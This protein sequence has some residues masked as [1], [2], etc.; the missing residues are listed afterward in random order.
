[1]NSMHKNNL[2]IIMVF[3]LFAS[4]VPGQDMEIY[5]SDAGNF[6]NP[7]W[8]ILKFDENGD[9]PQVFINSNL[10]WPQ[11]IVFLDDAGTVLISNF[12]GRI[13]RHD[14][15]TGTYIDDFASVPGQPTRMKIGS[16]NLLYVLQW[17]GNGKVRRYQLDGSFVDEFTNVG[18]PQS[19][20]LDWDSDGNMY[21][22]SYNGDS[23]RKFDT[24]GSD[25]G[26]FIN[27]NLVGPTDITFDSNGDLLVSDYDGAK[28]K[29]FDSNGNY[30]SDFIN[31]VGKV[32]GIDM[33]A[34]GNILVGVG[35][36]SSVRM[37]DAAGTYIETFISNGSGNLI[38]PNAIVIRNDN[39]GNTFKM[40]AGLNDAWYN[41]ATDGQGFFI[42]VFPDLEFV[43]LAWFTYDTEL[44]P[45][46][47]ESN[48]GDPGHRWLTALGSVEGNKAVLNI[49]IASGGLF[50]TPTVVDRVNDGT[51][52]L[53][54]DSCSS[55]TI[56]YDIPSIGKQGTVPIQRI[57]ADNISLCEALE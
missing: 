23:V 47:A 14:A 4:N 35:S 55:G 40:N 36:Q 44:P 42:T 38:A 32:E 7:P 33:F 46:D 3:L 54:F 45:Q 57:A 43:S 15:A 17:S 37:Y 30:L 19:I 5:V 50:D 49:S 21:V 31:G 39:T 26:L 16:D 6:N 10:N 8:Q 51:I 53:T 48:L 13:T 34:N 29:K 9:N 1:M 27:S 56:E 22:S 11:D 41:P 52:E 24:N 25:Q 12:G 28:V 20:G 18:V 2:I